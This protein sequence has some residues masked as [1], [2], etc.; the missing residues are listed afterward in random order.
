MRSQ[1]AMVAQKIIQTKTFPALNSNFSPEKKFEI[2][3]RFELP[4]TLYKDTNLEN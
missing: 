1:L 2:L 3:K 4:Q